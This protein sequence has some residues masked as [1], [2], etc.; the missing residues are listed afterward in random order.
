MELD[1]F[2]GLFDNDHE[3]LRLSDS[4]SKDSLLGS[5]MLLGPSSSYSSDPVGLSMI[6]TVNLAKG[7][8]GT[9]TFPVLSIPNSSIFSISTASLEIAMSPV[10]S[11]GPDTTTLTSPPPSS[12]SQSAQRKTAYTAKAQIEIIPCKVCGDKSSGVHYGVITC[13]GC[14]GFFRRSQSSVVNY[15]CARQ[16]ACLVDRVNRNRCQACRL[17]KCLALGM[18]RDAVKFGRMSKKQREKVEDEV[19]YHKEMNNQTSTGGGNVLNINSQ[20]GS[21]TSP[22]SSVFDPPQPSSTEHIYGNAGFYNN[23]TSPSYDNSNYPFSN[24]S[25]AVAISVAASTAQTTSVISNNNPTGSSTTIAASVPPSVTARSNSGNGSS[26]WTD[27]RVDSTTSNCFEQPQRQ[28]NLMNNVNA[29][30]VGAIA[31]DA[32]AGSGNSVNNN[33]VS[34]DRGGA[35]AAAAA[36]VAAAAAAVASARGCNANNTGS[37]IDTSQQLSNTISITTGLKTPA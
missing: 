17:Q 31:G 8:S 2:Q 30:I 10:S 3:Q 18:S 13:E 1:E 16:K 32:G 12:S 36:A 7:T 29:T 15:H 34:D 28:N 25:A 9:D 5:D 27:Y 24:L 26:D 14:K 11:Q 4:E 35:A 20:T 23:V 22:D 6:R 19:R 37:S 33:S 21:G